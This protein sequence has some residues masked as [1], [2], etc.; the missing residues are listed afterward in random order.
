VV[1]VKASTSSATFPATISS[2][3]QLDDT[4]V[5]PLFIGAIRLMLSADGNT[6]PEIASSVRD[7]VSND[8]TVRSTF[9]ARLIHAGLLL[10]QGTAYT[11]RFVH[12]QT[13][14]FRVSNAFPRITRAS[15]AAAVRK[16]RYELDLDRINAPSV[17]LPTVVALL[18]V[19]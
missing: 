14:L 3:E 10:S 4:L 2:L 7:A 12:T 19:G 9:D 1:E 15:V 6:L 13:R 5:Q 11:R 18:K 8:S 17:D 16:A